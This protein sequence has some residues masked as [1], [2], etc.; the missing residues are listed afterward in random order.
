MKRI[1]PLIL[2]FS[3]LLSGC[4]FFGERIKSPATFYYLCEYYTE[5]L[6]CVIASEERE[7]S[8][9]SS[10]LP[11]LLALYQ[12]SPADEGHR[13]PLPDGTAI[14]ARQQDDQICLELSDAAQS[15]SEL[16]FSLACACLTLTCLDISGAASV[17]VICGDRT[18]TMDRSSLTLFDTA[19][20]TKSTEETQ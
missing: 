14:Q 20:Q 15:L 2:V 19:E 18:R 6:C 5:E 4:G 7:A 12:M 1:L 3:L 9:H 13:S 11:Y 17:T 8:G 16:D 10:D